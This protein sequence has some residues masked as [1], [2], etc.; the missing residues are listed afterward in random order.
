MFNVGPELRE[1]GVKEIK[2]YYKNLPIIGN[3]FTVCLLLDE[4]R[5]ILSRG[6]SICSVLDYHDK[7]LAREKSRKRAISALC[8]KETTMAIADG[9]SDKDIEKRL[10]RGEVKR[11]FKVTDQK[12]KQELLK[13]ADELNLG[14]FP[15]DHCGKIRFYVPYFYP[16]DEARKYFSYKSEYNPTPTEQEKR[17]CGKVKNGV[18]PG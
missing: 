3:I 1:K 7:S 4:N 16:I 15:L 18:Q 17:I 2:Y 5:D 14:Y 10:I 12:K 9:V 13:A 8:K 11:V 6:V